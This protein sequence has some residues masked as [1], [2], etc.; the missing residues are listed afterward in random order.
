MDRPLARTMAP[1]GCCSGRLGMI[2]V[3]TST[4]RSSSP[5]AHERKGVWRRETMDRSLFHALATS[6]GCCGTPRSNNKDQQEIHGARVR[7]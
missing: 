3:L 2:A 1:G 4:S 5:R 6:G 7:R